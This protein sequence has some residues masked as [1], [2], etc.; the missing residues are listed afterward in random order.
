MNVMI[1][2]RYLDELRKCARENVDFISAAISVYISNDEL[3]C[4]IDKKLQEILCFINRVYNPE[5]IKLERQWKAYYQKWLNLKDV[6]EMAANAIYLE[7]IALM[8]K[9]DAMDIPF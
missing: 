6:D 8:H 3:E 1:D 9:I 2:K 7:Y 5:L 4:A